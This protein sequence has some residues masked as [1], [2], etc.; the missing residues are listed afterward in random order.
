MKR[1]GMNSTEG[2]WMKTRK[3]GPIVAYHIIE[4]ILPKCCPYKDLS[5]VWKFENSLSFNGH[6]ATLRSIE[7]RAS[8][9][10]SL[11]L[12]PLQ[13]FFIQVYP[14][15]RSIRYGCEGGAEA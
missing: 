2:R 9:C 15:S 8:V 3:E 12:V 7:M 4:Q 1:G 5:T 10:D 11:G 6:F 14:Q 13:L